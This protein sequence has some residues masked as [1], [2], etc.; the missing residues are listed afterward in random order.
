VPGMQGGVAPRLHYLGN[1]RIHLHCI[2][3]VF[4]L[5]LL[6]GSLAVLQ[7]LPLWWVE[8]CSKLQSTTAIRYISP[9]LTTSLGI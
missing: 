2:I 5:T 7:I 4:L 6:S 1:E 8:S 3:H 9:Y